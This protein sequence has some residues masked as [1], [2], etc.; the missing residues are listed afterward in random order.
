MRYNQKAIFDRNK[1]TY[2][3]LTEQTLEANT[4]FTIA[5]SFTPF[6]N[7]EHHMIG[8][9]S[10]DDTIRVDTTGAHRIAIRINNDFGSMTGTGNVNANE[11][12]FCVITRTTGGAFSVYRNGVKSTASFTNTSDFKYQYLGQ[13]LN[14][15]WESDGLLDE[16][17]IFNTH[18]SD[19]EAQ[20][21]FNDGVA[22]DATTH[23]KKGNLIGYWRNDGVTTW[24]DRRGW[25]FLDFDG[26]SDEVTLDSELTFTGVF[27]VS[28]WVKHNSSGVEYVLGKVGGDQDYFYAHPTHPRWRIND[29]IISSDSDMAV[30]VW[31]HVLGVRDSS[32]NFIWYLN[33][34][35]AT[36]YNG[37]SYVTTGVT[38]SGDF[39]VQYFGRSLNSYGEIELTNVAFFN[40][41][42]SSSASTFYN[43]GLSY[44]YSTE[45]G[46]TNY[47]KMD[48][49]STLLDRVGS[50]N[51]TVDATLND[52]NDGT[53]SGSP[54]SITIREGLNS[55]RDGLGFYFTNPSSNVLRL[56]GV[57]E[58][59]DIGNPK[60]LQFQSAFTI[61]CWVKTYGALSG[62]VRIISKDDGTNRSYILHSNNGKPVLFIF[63]N[64][65]SASSNESTVDIDDGNWHYVVGV[66]DGT[67]LSIFQ[68]NGTTMTQTA[69]STNGGVI[70]NDSA[71]VEIG[72]FASGSGSEFFK[73]LI[74]E[75]TMY[76]KALS[77]TEIIKNYKHGK[78][79]HKND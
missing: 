31:H 68:S 61:G 38:R 22:L 2:V 43:N 60:T 14:G 30:G 21:L 54:D 56:N 77:L 63:K 9:N 1:N 76:N 24:Q 69:T 40:T 27:S 12:H 73:G 47:Y 53:V 78:G 79:K 51:G 20:E 45:S 37:S 34:S 58:Y 26:S 72:R 52:G 59:V 11:S 6:N 35:L 18:F 62:Y 75:V 25:S 65:G 39:D 64:G 49:S 29:N 17:S 33:G 36:L 13:S 3:S 19:A 41:D 71:N 7:G 15:G 55:N 16:F 8:K 67:N 48:S 74:D 50:V 5:F 28:F 44:D 42:K 32:D 57:D 4:A 46:I 66:H 23:S 70:D 10:T